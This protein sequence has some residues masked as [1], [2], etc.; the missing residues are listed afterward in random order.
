MSGAKPRR[1]KQPYALALADRGLMELA[2]VWENWQ[3]PAGE[4]MRSFA[5]ITTTP[6]ELC[7]EIHNRMPVIL[8]PEAWPAWLGEKPAEVP[9]LKAL[10]APYPSEDMICWPVSARVGNVRNNDSAGEAEMRGAVGGGNP[11]DPETVALIRRLEEALL[12]PEVRKSA[13]QIAALLAD[14]FVEIGSS[15]RIYDKDQII[16]QLQQESGEESLR[17]VSDFT[18][19]ELADGLIL[20][21]YPIIETR[22]VRSSIWKRTNSEWRMVFHQGTKFM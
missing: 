2:G 18:A 7:A 14:E 12:V 10:L 16:G 22:T 9:Q 4:W 3:S 6:N 15:G 5:I 17:T 20:V 8:K 1:G 21:T 13:A 19:R 11:A